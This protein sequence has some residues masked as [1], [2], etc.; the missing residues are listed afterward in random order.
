MLVYGECI[1]CHYAK[2]RKKIDKTP[3]KVL[4]K[5]V[6][7]TINYYA[8]TAH[9]PWKWELQSVHAHRVADQYLD[10]CA[11]LGAEGPKRAAGLM[12]DLGKYG[13]LFN[14]V[15]V[16]GG[17]MVWITGAQG[18]GRCYASTT[19]KALQQHWRLKVITS[20]CSP[21]PTPCAT[22]SA[23]ER[24]EALS[25]GKAH[26]SQGVRLSSEDMPSGKV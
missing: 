23:K 11:T 5:E 16:T 4:A 7:M 15:Y 9:D 22:C 26:L 24:M 8:R 18:L 19:L 20:D 25:Q 2:F 14:N 17:C 1:K 13:E 6:I 10:I 21:L 12:H 3:N